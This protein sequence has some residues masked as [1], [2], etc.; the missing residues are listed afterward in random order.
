MTAWRK[1]GIAGNV[2]AP[3]LIDRSEFIDQPPV[4]T[5]A[6]VSRDSGGSP[7]RSTRKRAADLVKTP[8]GMA[9]GSLES[10]RAKVARLLEHAQEL[11]KELEAP[12]D[13]TAA[14]LL[15]PDV[16]TR[17]DKPARAGRK[18]LSDLHG[19]TTMRALGAEAEARRLDDEA[20]AEGVAQRKREALEKKQAAE[21]EAV[22]R[23]AAFAK[24]EAACT[25]GVV[26]CPWAGWKRCPVCGPKKGLC[27]VRA[28]KA[29]R[30]PLL[31]GYTPAVEGQEGAVVAVEG[32]EGA[33]VAA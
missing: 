7:A 10:E 25:C 2:L 17:P 14:N 11:E 26:P 8:E 33:V 12:F 31:L 29:A 18:R 15:I 28:C 27:K 22:E 19:S 30:E 23:E 20:V 5:P 21:Q 32:Q 9:S 16:V 13:P 24:C 6:A 4:A 1:V 3:E